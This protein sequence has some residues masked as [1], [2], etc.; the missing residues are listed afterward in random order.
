MA[1]KINGVYKDI[2]Y[3]EPKLVGDFSL[4]SLVEFCPL[5][6]SG[7]NFTLLFNEQLLKSP[8]YSIKIVDLKGGYLITYTPPFIRPDYKIVSQAKF[9]RSLFNL[10]YDDGVKLT[11]QTP[12]D[13]YTQKINEEIT[14]GEFLSLSDSNDFISLL[15]E[16]EKK[17]IRVFRTPDK[18]TKI[19]EQTA[20]EIIVHDRR[21]TIT[22]IKRDIAKHK[23]TCVYSLHGEELKVIDKKIDV[24]EKFIQS[25]LAEKIVP[26]AFLEEVCVGGDFSSY[27][28]S[29]IL[30]KKDMINDY[31]GKFIGVI[32][33]P[34]FR[35]VREIGLIYKDG[36]NNYQ[37]RYVL[38]DTSSGKVANLRLLDD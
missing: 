35:S 2:I 13:F 21:I 23:I 20:D 37:V 6:S 34:S 24:S 33:P 12:D 31:L 32:P 15:T 8:P 18:I 36:P 4:D 29:E 1:L 38:T 25:R 26:Y 28:S 19:F 16:G 11:V 3:K 22:E 5:D 27:L 7:D 10:F 14:G 30:E 17:T 9:Q